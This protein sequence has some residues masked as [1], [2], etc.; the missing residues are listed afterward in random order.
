MNRYRV[1]KLAGGKIV[2]TLTSR[3][4]GASSAEALA[5]LRDEWGACYGNSGFDV[6]GQQYLVVSVHPDGMIARNEQALFRLE[7]VSRPYE[8]VPVSI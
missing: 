7:E 4:Y 1:Y 6:V 5:N 3:A 2:S 8:L